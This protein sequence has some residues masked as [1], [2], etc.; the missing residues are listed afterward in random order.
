MKFE[1]FALNVSDAVAASSWYE[2]HL[3]LTVVKKMA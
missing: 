2:E 3:G 1:H